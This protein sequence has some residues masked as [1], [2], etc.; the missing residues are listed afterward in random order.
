MIPQVRRSLGLRGILLFCSCLSV[1]LAGMTLMN[2]AYQKRIIERI[3]YD[4]VH[5]LGQL[6]LTAMIHPMLSGDQYV[7]QKQF[8]QYKDLPTVVLAHLTDK[9]GIIRRST[10]K[11]LIG[12]KSLSPY[13]ASALQGRPYLGLELRERT[14]EMII[15][16]LI[17]IFNEQRCYG[18]HGAND[19]VLGVVRLGLDWGMVVASLRAS[20]KWNILLSFSGMLVMSL[21]IAIFFMRLV[22][23]PIRKLEVG[24]R[25]VSLGDLTSKVAIARNDE[26]GSLTRL[27]NRMTEDLRRL[28]NEEKKKSSEFLRLN[29]DLKAEITERERVENELNQSKQQLANIIDFLPDNT[30]AIDL[31]GKIIAWN[32]AMEEMSGIRALDALGKGDYEYALPFYGIRRPI[33]VDWTLD[34]SLE[35]QEKYLAFER[36]G[37]KLTGEVFAPC[38]NNGAGAM[39][40]AIATPLYDINGAVVGAIESVRDI[41]AI[42]QTEEKLRHAYDDLKQIQSQLVQSAKM[43]SVGSLAGGVAHEINN[44]LTGVLNN[45]QLINILAR[46]KKD[47]NLQDFKELLAVIEE[48]AQRCVKITRS[49]LDFSHASKGV[50]H[51]LNVNDLVEKVL[52]FIGH[53]MLLENILIQKHLDPAI[54]LVLGDE[55]LIQQII[56]DIISNGRW[57]IREKRGSEGGLITLSTQPDSE[58][59]NVLIKIFDDGIGIPKEHLEKIFE[60]FFTTRE[61]G[62]GTGLGLA[63]VYSIVKEHGGTI[64]VDS[65]QGQG[66]NFTIRLPVSESGL[67]GNAST[68]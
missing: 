34:P 23:S 31:E 64:E 25:K 43:A 8:D 17:P 35:L 41:T 54:G 46:E 39:L 29:F 66:T 42:K 44:P 57:A 28:V 62:Q 7:I 37:A 61:V 10:D 13:L 14:K 3:A 45:V 22:V 9:K 68:P 27:F 6:I 11:Q 60:P 12:R 50:Y 48:S 51:L 5:Q 30:F 49:L 19:K 15:A 59:K 40:W 63:I 67:V 16:D 20:R 55:Q 18:C 21:L 1:I 2:V 52:S 56:F 65:E 38:L 32:K 24:M 26:I 47:F 33:L 4:N 36:S 58:H 53:D